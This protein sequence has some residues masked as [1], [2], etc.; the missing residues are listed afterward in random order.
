MKK[1]DFRGGEIVASY[2][3]EMAK[4]SYHELYKMSSLFV[5]AEISAIKIT[6][7]SIAIYFSDTK[8]P[9][10]V[11][12]K[13]NSRIRELFKEEC[14]IR[15]ENFWLCM[16]EIWNQYESANIKATRE[17]WEEWCRVI[18]PFIHEAIPKKEKRVA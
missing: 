9:V 15:S 10:F 16:G 14:L 13:K 7:E 12:A 4:N 18:N 1:I 2:M 6:E 11:S 17:L 3:A 8:D 5:K